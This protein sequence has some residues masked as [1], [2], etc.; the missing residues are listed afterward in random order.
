[1]HVRP[2]RASDAPLIVTFEDILA[3]HFSLRFDTA[4]E[5]AES[6]STADYSS[7]MAFVAV[8]AEEIIGVAT[9]DRAD[10][11]VPRAEIA[12]DVAQPYRQQGVATLLFE[13]LAA[14]AR[15]QGVERFHATV[16]ADNLEMVGVL[17]ALGLA[18]GDRRL[19]RGG[20]TL[21]SIYIPPPS[22]SRRAKRREAVAEAASMSVILRPR[23][24]AVV[25][26]GRRA[27]SPGHEVVRS[28]L[29]GDV[30]GTVYPVNP[31]AHSICGVPA[32]PDLSSLPERVDLAIVAVPAENV[33]KVLE[34]AALN[35]V[36]AV[37]IITAG[38]AET[39]R[40]RGRGRD[41]TA[42]DG[43]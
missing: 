31:K 27:G 21:I 26:A 37:T 16:S 1:M 14:Y 18:N 24:I 29:A 17:R 30:A 6:L 7:S 9:Y 20:V 32:F 15:S 11:S 33:L 34:E 41:R 25:G 5:A 13:A 22:T 35:G 39:G 2:I 12:F 3:P 8:V 36:R 23:V 4:E 38:F 40:G 28:L 19:R 10:A 43:S 42:V